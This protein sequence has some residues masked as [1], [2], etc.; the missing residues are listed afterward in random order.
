MHNSKVCE[1]RKAFQA[2]QY[3]TALKCYEKVAQEIGEKFFKANIKICKSQICKEPV[4]IVF[5]CDENYVI[6]TYV[7]IYSLVKNMDV[8][9]KYNIFVVTN[10]LSKVSS[11]LFMGIT[12]ANV[13]IT[14]VCCSNKFDEFKINKK[15]FHVSTSAILKFELPQL[16]NTIDKVLYIDGD[17]IVQKDISEFF[18]TD[19]RDSYAGVIKDMKPILKY[20][21]SVLTK[22][23]IETHDGYFNSGVLLLNLK[24]MR[25]DNITEMLFEYR[26]N[27][28]NFFMDQDALNVVF[29]N[30]VKYFDLYFNT[31]M[32][33]FEE[34]SIGQI[35]LYYGIS[36]SSKSVFDIIKK[37]YIIHFASKNKPWNFDNKKFDGIWNR[38][39]IRS[40]LFGLL[41]KGE[42]FNCK[43]I[44]DV[45]VSLTSYPKRISTVHYTIE[46]ILNQSFKASKVI[47][48]LAEEQFPCREKELPRSLLALKEKG[49]II[50]WCS[51]MK[52]YKKLIPALKRYPKNIIVTADDDILYHEHWLLE[53][54]SSYISNP[55][56]IH[57]HR[58]HYINIGKDGKPLSYRAWV[59]NCKNDE[60][61]LSFRNFFTGVG[62]VLYPPQSLSNDVFRKDLFME[63]CPSGDDIWF[64][65]MALLQGTKIQR[66][67]FSSFSLNFVED[68]QKT[69]LHKMNDQGGRND[70]MLDRLICNYHQLINIINE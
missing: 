54:I 47:L 51:D 44:N 40:N 18:F 52:S 23:G 30:K 63:L 42:K 65:G 6:P 49:L 56:A 26:K 17:V 25:E 34:F 36:D 41:E 11:S 12:C 24:K 55:K 14:I 8:N 46:T 68:T 13:D 19:I 1:A 60:N 59:R 2:K 9:K 21:P 29:G 53:L 22:L 64:F 70:I 28:L 38:Y 3:S 66:V 5:I 67:T 10:N 31:L 69:A 39:F 35:K 58:S 37:S 15:D 43:L 20:R 33:L 27:G 16:L 45:V 4:N 50:S 32:T 7:S 57:C 61:L 48:W 62:G